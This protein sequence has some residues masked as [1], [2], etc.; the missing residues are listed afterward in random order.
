ME[1]FS[2]IEDAL[3]DIRE[4]KM[5]I[6]VDDESRENEGD[7]I[8]AA[9]KVDAEKINFIAKHARGLICV[10]LLGKRL[11]EL[12]L[13]MMVQEN[14]ARMNT[15]FTVSVDAIHGTTTGISAFDRAVTI[16]ALIDP[17][18]RPED[19]ARPGHI[20]PLRA[21]DSGVLR[22]AGHTEAA[23]DLTRMAGLR[24]GGLL[25]EIMAEDGSMAR[26][27]ELRDFSEKFGLRMITICDLIEYR[28]KKEKLIKRI[29]DASLPTRYGEFRLLAYEGTI[30]GSESVALVMGEPWKEEKALVRVHSQCLTGDVFHSLRC[31]CGNQLDAAMKMIAERGSGVLL[32][33]QQEGRGIGLVN[34]VRAYELQDR[35]RDTVEANEELGFPADLRDYGTGAQILAD[36]GLHKIE[37]LTNN[38]KKII[39]LKAYGLEVVERVSIET[40]PNTRNFRYLSTKREKLG[41]LFS[42][43]TGEE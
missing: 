17:G 23:V 37:L 8:M 41:H 33:I 20:F 5:V 11:G 19:L 1:G 28:R 12:R 42:D 43:L 26:G 3:E 30:D 21:V 14:T 13:G 36:L 35:G 15:P 39:G 9:E 6:V 18:T 32:Y 40:V 27:A 34:K 16:K 7:I 10:A 4:G 29:A 25:C 22:R 24:P 31:D 38:P 2:S